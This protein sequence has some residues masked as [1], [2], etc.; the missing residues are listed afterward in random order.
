MLEMPVGIR[1]AQPTRPNQAK[2]IHAH[3]IHSSPNPAT[4]VN[5]IPSIN[6]NTC[7][8]FRAHSRSQSN[9]PAERIVRLA[10]LG[11]YAMALLGLDA[12]PSPCKKGPPTPSR[13]AQIQNADA[14]GHASTVVRLGGAVAVTYI[15]A[16]FN[17]LQK[18]SC[19]SYKCTVDFTRSCIACHRSS[20]LL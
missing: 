9:L 7:R 12:K 17:L 11:R 8:V 2:P 1:D 4:G 13:E 5:S 20:L 6:A 14:L 15:P 18:S 10:R 19:S 3:S 16:L